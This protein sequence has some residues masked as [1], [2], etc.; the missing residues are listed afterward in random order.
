MK[1]LAI[2]FGVVASLLVCA[3]PASAKKKPQKR[4]GVTRK[5]KTPK[6]NLAQIYGRSTDVG[7]VFATERTLVAYIQD[8][9]DVGDSIPLR[10]LIRSG[11]AELTSNGTKIEILSPKL[12]KVPGVGMPYVKVMILS[13]CQTGYVCWSDVAA[14]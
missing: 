10:S 5:A 7:I 11:L 3:Y 1:R 8:C 6:R 12:L 2:M 14:L 4:T 9:S 13:T